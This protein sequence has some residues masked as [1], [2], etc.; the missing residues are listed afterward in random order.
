VRKADNFNNSRTDFPQIW[1]SQN[2]ENLWVC[3]RTALGMLNLTFSSAALFL[4]INGSQI[5]PRGPR[6]G[7]ANFL[8][9]QNNFLVGHRNFTV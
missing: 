2:P 6:E 8:R 7:N 5:W 9:G 4:M 1:D 3:N